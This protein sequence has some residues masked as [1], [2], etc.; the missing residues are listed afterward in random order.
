MISKA[1]GRLVVGTMKISKRSREAR[2]ERRKKEIQEIKDLE[3][4]VEALVPSLPTLPTTN[5]AQNEN[6]HKNVELFSDLPLSQATQQGRPSESRSTEADERTE[7]SSLH[8]H[9]GYSEKGVACRPQGQRYSWCCKDRQWQ[10]SRIHH[11]CNPTLHKR[12]GP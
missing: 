1:R 12:T 7:K 6:E 8:D 3:G 11:P 10:D 2:A 4:R 9:D 5:P